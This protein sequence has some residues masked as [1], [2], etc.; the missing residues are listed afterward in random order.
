MTTCF[1]DE[2]V[3]DSEPRPPSVIEKRM[4]ESKNDDNSL[5]WING[6]ERKECHET[7]QKNRIEFQEDWKQWLLIEGIE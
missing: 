5:I 3:S 2:V 6:G 1:L 4:E 7:I